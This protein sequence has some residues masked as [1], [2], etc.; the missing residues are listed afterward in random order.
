LLRQPQQAEL[1]AANETDQQVTFTNGGQRA[2]SGGKIP[3]FKVI[4]PACSSALVNDSEL[5][6]IGC[7]SQLRY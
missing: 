3:K 7:K 1:S 6:L 5:A 2:A 4:S